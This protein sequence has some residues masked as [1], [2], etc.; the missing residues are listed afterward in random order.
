MGRQDFD[1]APRIKVKTIPEVS[2]QIS[3]AFNPIDDKPDQETM[4]GG[5][6]DPGIEDDYDDKTE[7]IDRD[8]HPADQEEKVP[9]EQQQEEAIS[10]PN[11]GEISVPSEEERKNQSSGLELA[12]IKDTKYVIT[13]S[14]ERKIK[15]DP[16][17]FLTNLM[18]TAKEL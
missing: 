5:R 16:R 2:P 3:E 6:R 15:V 10:K 13:K 17:F 4:C 1:R 9:P 8:G 7:I 11:E 14:E 18:R 12:N